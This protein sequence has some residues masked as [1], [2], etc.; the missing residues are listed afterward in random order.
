MRIG[1]KKFLIILISL[2]PLIFLISLISE[3][4]ISFDDVKKEME[5]VESLMESDF[6]R[7]AQSAA[8][9]SIGRGETIF[10]FPEQKLFSLQGEVFLQSQEA[11]PESSSFLPAESEIPPE[12]NESSSSG[13]KRVYVSHIEGTNDG[14]AY[15]TNY[16]TFGIVFAPTYRPGKW[17]PMFDFRVHRFDS[18][19][20]YA[21]N[22]GVIARYVPDSLDKF[23]SCLGFNA[24]YDFRQGFIGYYQQIGSGVEII[25][26]RWD[27]RGN[28][29]FPV[30]A[31]KHNRFCVYNY[32]GGYVITNS[33]YEYVSFAFNAEVGCYLINTCSFLFYGAIG[34][35]YI[36]G[37]EGADSTRGGRARIRPQFADYFALDL[38]VSYDD[39]FK[40]VWQAEVILSLPLYQ[41]FSKGKSSKTSCKIADRRIY[42]PVE[43]FEVMPLGIRECWTQNY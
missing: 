18:D 5:N 32:T 25:G 38:S 39:L 19:N 43:R 16:S 35:Y 4:F 41:I 6:E 40:T 8:A 37:R 30:G 26:H 20:I 12:S 34:P 27:L 11:Y 13:P 29:Y 1:V 14:V 22:G 31:R 7:V 36:A 23:C 28:V 10:P 42:Q 17:L 9:L 2:I 21:F 33:K 3:I 15:T 24:Y